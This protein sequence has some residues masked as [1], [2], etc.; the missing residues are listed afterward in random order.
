MPRR[1]QTVYPRMHIDPR[2]NIC[3]YVFGS[4][5]TSL[6]G[7]HDLDI[8]IVY[9]RNAVPPDRIYPKL[10]AFLYL[11]QL[12]FGLP[13]HPTVLTL[14]E[15]RAEQFVE[16]LKCIPLDAWQEGQLINRSATSRLCIALEPEP[17]DLICTSERKRTLRKA[18]PA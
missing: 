11:L 2:E 17:Q 10:R 4:A 6:E 16:R 1:T 12:E 5:V 3:C 18:L 7:A 9:H 14:E 8:L 13:V 15:E